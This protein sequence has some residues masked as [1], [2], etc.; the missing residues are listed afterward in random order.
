[1]LERER[2]RIMEDLDKIKSGQA[3]LRRNDAA[4]MAAGT[5]LGLGNGVSGI[6]NNQFLEPS[7]KEKLIND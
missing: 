1:M 6:L 5:S 7:L 2:A 4:R 3:L